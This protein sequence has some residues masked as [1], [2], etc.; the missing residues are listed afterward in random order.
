MVGRTVI[1]SWEELNKCK[2]DTHSLE[3][4]LVM[5]RGRVKS[6]TD[7]EDS[8]YLSTHSFYESSYKYTTQILNDRGFNVEI[9]NW[10]K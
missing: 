2:S 1:K 6:K 4:D 10:D 5:G 3:I 8:V 7:S 9:D